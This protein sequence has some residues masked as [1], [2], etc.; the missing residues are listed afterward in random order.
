MNIKKSYLLFGK[1]YLLLI[2]SV[3]IFSVI[4]ILMAP[5]IHMSYRIVTFTLS[6]LFLKAIRSSPLRLILAIPFLFLCSA[7]ISL[8]LYSWFTFKTPF[9]DGFAVSTLESNPSEMI[10]MLGVYL[11]FVI[12][13]LALL[14]LFIFAVRPIPGKMPSKKITGTLILII[15]LIALV[16][17]LKFVKK[18]PVNEGAIS[19]LKVAARFTTYMPFF[20]ISYFLT[21]M[22]ESQILKNI[23]GAAPHYTLTVKD[24]GIDTYVLIIG[25]SER[26]RNMSI[27]GYKKPTT[28]QLES[29]KPYLKLFT[30]AISGVPFTSVAVP[31]ALSADN[32]HNHD[33]KNYADNVINLANQ[34][35]FHTT[36]LSAQTAFGNYGSSVAGI[37]M[38]AKDKLYIKGY[39]KELIPHLKTALAKPGHDKKLI[40]LH[41]YGSHEPACARYPSDEAIFDKNGDID[42]CYDNSVRYTDSLFGEIF[43]LLKRK[44][45]SV[46]Y[47]S[48][49][50][51]ERDPKQSAPYFHGGIT[52]SQE[53]YHVPMFIWYSPVLEPRYQ[54]EIGQVDSVYSTSY[55][56]AAI[57]TWLGITDASR[58]I[59]SNVNDVVNKF[60][61]DSTVLDNLY[62]KL[63]YHS[64]RKTAQEPLPESSR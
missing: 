29:Q 28:P 4:N 56:D 45:A 57:A 47:F 6:L 61:N 35:G 18:R 49:H 25:E 32:I 40:I 38:N 27:Y 62:Q 54:Q 21:A 1:E 55:N 10:A 52:P 34:A 7:D 5:N 43:S 22:Q 14:V 11:R 26:A 50:A 44:N 31:M 64:L 12:V 39:D 9:N 60:K 17:S 41:L 58:G 33:L 2:I 8:S 24:T 15:C 13:C 3:M 16:S 20:N 46:F 19:E 37:A 59:F 30:Q 36:W 63:D 48:D 53:A 42:A 23:S 51:L